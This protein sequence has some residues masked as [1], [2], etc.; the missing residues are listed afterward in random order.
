M[1][2][3]LRWSDHKSTNFKTVRWFL[4]VFEIITLGIL[5]FSFSMTFSQYNEEDMMT[6]VIVSSFMVVFFALPHIILAITSNPKETVFNFETKTIHWLHKKKEVKTLPFHSLKRI[7]YSDYSYTVKTKNGS[8]TVTVY[9][10]MGHSDSENFQLIES[11]N[12]SKLRFDGELICKHLALPLQTANGVLIEPKDLDLPIHKRKIPTS[13]L[14]SNI[15]FSPNSGLS[16][17]KTNEGISLRSQ[18]KSKVI[19]FVSVFLS[20]AFTLFIHFAFGDLFEVSIAYWET[21][22]PTLA[23]ILF[24]IGSLSVGFIPFLYSFYQQNRNKEIK[25]TKTALVWNGETYPY[26]NWEDL[27]QMENRLCLVNDSKMESFSLFFFCE[28]SD[29]TNIKHWL[30]KTIFEQSGGDLDLARFG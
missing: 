13:V 26:E 4:I 1:E 14:E 6:L 27:I 28:L 30:Q 16:I 20:I 8:R 2:K 23:E 25:V 29:V 9:T 10:V 24:L 22:P 15:S 7:T 21:L 3:E 12:F 19:L 18:Y 5:A 11:T 17:E